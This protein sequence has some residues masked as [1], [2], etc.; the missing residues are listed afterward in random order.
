MSLKQIRISSKAGSQAW[1]NA[2]RSGFSESSKSS[3]NGKTPPN[4]SL[5]EIDLYAKLKMDYIIAKG[6]DGAEEWAA[7]HIGLLREHGLVGSMAARQELFNRIK[8]K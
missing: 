7:E 3:T 6:D 4:M 1:R 8:H 2:Q 5:F